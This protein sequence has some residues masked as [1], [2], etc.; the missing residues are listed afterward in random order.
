MFFPPLVIN[1]EDFYIHDLFP[2]YMLTGIADTLISE[3]LDRSI[4]SPTVLLL[5][6]FGIVKHR[7][8]KERKKGK[9]KR[10]KALVS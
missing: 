4:F 8:R 6:S 2:V 7:K 10:K 3:S 5:A 9:K 1:T